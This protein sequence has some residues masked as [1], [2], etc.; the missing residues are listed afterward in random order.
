M[1]RITQDMRELASAPCA[2]ASAPPATTHP[3]L[4]P[5]P[6]YASFLD[7]LSILLWPRF[8]ALLDTHVASLRQAS[9]PAALL[10]V[11]ARARACACLPC[12]CLNPSQRQSLRLCDPSLEL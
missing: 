7:A 2:S 9:V 10:Q 12:V 11:G 3:S 5:L 1:I 4:R 8:K 6:F